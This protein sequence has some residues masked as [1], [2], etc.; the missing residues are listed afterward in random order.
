MLQKVTTLHQYI[1]PCYQTQITVY[2]LIITI[3][4][5]LCR[6]RIVNNFATISNKFTRNQ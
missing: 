6:K 2:F 1:S 5:E 3:C 4:H